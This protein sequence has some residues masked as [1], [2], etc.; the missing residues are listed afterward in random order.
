MRL[1]H[2]A[3]GPAIELTGRVTPAICPR[4]PVK[5]D[6]DERPHERL[7]DFRIAFVVEAQGD[8][9]RFEH[10]EY[11][12]DIPRAVPELH[13]MQQPLIPPTSVEAREETYPGDP[14]PG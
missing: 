12:R 10:L 8:M 9:S 7:D 5:A 3:P 2:E 4:R 6:V 14:D 13:H 1:L 11:L